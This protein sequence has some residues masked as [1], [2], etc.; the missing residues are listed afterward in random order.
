[1]FQIDTPTAVPSMP[2]LNVAASPGW[3]TSGNPASAQPATVVSADWLNQ[4]QS[5]LLAILTA[6]GVTQSKTVLNQLQ[7]AIYNQIPKP[8]TTAPLMN[9]AAATGTSTL[10]S[11]QDHVHPVDTSRCAALSAPQSNS[12]GWYMSF[13][14]GFI[15]QGGCLSDGSGWSNHYFPIAF[16]TVCASVQINEGAVNWGGWNGGLSPTIHGSANQGR[17]YFLRG[18]S[19]WN[20]SSWN[21]GNF[22]YSWTAFGW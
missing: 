18:S 22:T 6:G 12:N 8:S 17:L 16:P 14:N 10:F 4:L 13:P 11:R 7:T 9:N 2:A 3:F 21:L 5:E 1:M 20:G 19:G 15:I